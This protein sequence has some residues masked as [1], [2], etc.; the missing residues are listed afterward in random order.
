V[1][2]LPAPAD[3]YLVGGGDALR[4]DVARMADNIRAA[5]CHV[6]IEV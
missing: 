2:P 5:G 3:A 1:I 6:E 4:D